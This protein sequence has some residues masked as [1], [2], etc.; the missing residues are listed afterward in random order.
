MTLSPR[1]DAAEP[2]GSRRMALSCRFGRISVAG[3]AFPAAVVLLA[4][5]P[6]GFHC[7]EDY[8]EE[9]LGLA[10][11]GLGTLT[12]NQEPPAVNR[13]EPLYPNNGINWNDYVLA[14]GPSFFSASDVP[15]TGT[16]IGG[17]RK[18]IHG[19]EKRYV[20]VSNGSSCGNVAARDNLDAFV[21]T[22]DDST[23]TVRMITGGLKDGKHLS[24]L[25]DFTAASF[26]PMSVT[27]TFTDTNQS[28]TTPETIWWF[29]AITANPPPGNLN[30]S[31][32]IYIFTA[33]P[34]GTFTIT[35]DRVA[36]VGQ[37]GV[38]LTGS[39]APTEQLLRAINRTFVWIEGDWELADDTGPSLNNTHF[40]V[41]R[42][43]RITQT[44]GGLLN[45]IVLTGGSSNNYL[46]HIR[47][48]GE[49][50]LRGL[51]NGA[52]NKYNTYYRINITGT[53]Y[54]FYF[55]D[56]ANAQCHNNVLLNYLILANPSSAMVAWDSNSNVSLNGGT[57]WSNGTYP[58]VSWGF[59]TPRY[60]LLSNAYVIN[61]RVRGFGF[62]TTGGGNSGPSDRNQV[63]D[64]ALLHHQGAPGVG[65]TNMDPASAANYITG[66]LI[67]GN[68]LQDCEGV[69]GNGILTG[70]NPDLASDFTYI[71]GQSAITSFVGP[72]TV[73]D[74]ANPSDTNG[75]VG[76]L[77]ADRLNFD[78][79]LRTLGRDAV[80][81][82]ANTLYGGCNVAPCRIWD[83]RL[84]ASDGVFRNRLA[85]PNGNDVFYHIWTEPTQTDC[86][87]IPGAVWQDQV[88]S[89][90]GYTSAAACTGAGGTWSTGL[91]STTFL[92]RA[93]ERINDGIGN[94]NGLC[95]SNETCI[96]TPNIGPYQGHGNL[97]SAGAFT[98]G[99]ISNV[100]L[101]R[102]ET[103]GM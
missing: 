49:Q 28:A 57:L 61:H 8:P 21:W 37:P 66:L 20:E 39:A 97:V 22:C 93:Y 29:N 4:L 71:P 84:R 54:G 31:G 33:N 30:V 62:S 73:D 76:S 19:A 47:I 100:T 16:E 36:M 51:E 59:G 83:F 80:D 79:W 27:V 41:M 15:C 75:L 45:A 81:V 67:A 95:E 2:G 56:A 32:T 98:D 11:A 23:G 35:G 103:N 85:V 99:I 10:L 87:N 101:L 90:P 53:N 74:G 68:N 63:A 5:L 72:L 77:P 9:G 25:I 64:L 34:A 55:G 91:C 69:A 102:Y 43:V 14:D 40:S 89:L 60:M 26:R 82:S 18:C 70:C 3:A 1:N 24:D 38:L 58:G 17:Y 50:I 7:V 52:G 6:F 12:E 88:C 48:N 94:E 44:G 78:H 13:V 96:Y 86:Q 92:R 65:F 42:N 46:T